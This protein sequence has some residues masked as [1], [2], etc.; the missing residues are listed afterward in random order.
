MVDSA[1]KKFPVKIL[2]IIVLE[3]AAIMAAASV[4]MSM[5]S[6]TEFRMSCHELERYKA[7]LEKSSHAVDK[8]NNPTQSRQ[9]HVPLVS[10][11]IL[12]AVFCS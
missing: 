12:G 9:C 2:I 4:S 8:D 7:E 3:L 10:I 6:R 11:A 1:P 5:T